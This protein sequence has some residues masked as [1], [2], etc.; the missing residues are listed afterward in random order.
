MWR[1]LHTALIIFALALPC[2]GQDSGV[3]SNYFAVQQQ[4]EWC[5]SG[6]VERCQAAGIAVTEPTLWDYWTGQNRAKLLNVKVDIKQCIPYF[7]KPTISNVLETLQTEGSSALGWSNHVHF[8]QDVG[9]PTNSLDETPYFKTQYHDVTGGWQNVHVMIT[10]LVRTQR[11]MTYWPRTNI[12]SDA[13]FDTVVDP[14]G[15]YWQGWS[16]LINRTNTTDIAKLES[17]YVANC[18][19]ALTYPPQTLYDDVPGYSIGQIGLDPN[20][21]GWFQSV[22]VYTY[23]TDLDTVRLGVSNH[24]AGFSFDELPR[25]FV[26]AYGESSGVF[27]YDPKG[28]GSVRAT[29]EK[30]TRNMRDALVWPG[31]AG[32]E[33]TYG[34]DVFPQSGSMNTFSQPHMITG[35][36]RWKCERFATNYIPDE[37]DTNYT[38][39]VDHTNRVVHMDAPGG[40]Y[41]VDFYVTNAVSTNGYATNITEQIIGSDF[42]VSFANNSILGSRKENENTGIYLPSEFAGHNWLDVT[43]NHYGFVTNIV[44]NIS[45]EI[46]WVSNSYVGYNVTYDYVVQDAVSVT[47]TP[48]P[49][50][51]Y[52]I[53]K[54]DPPCRA[55]KTMV[56]NY[57][58]LRNLPTNIAHTVDSFASVTTYP[59]NNDLSCWN[60]SSVYKYTDTKNSSFDAFGLGYTNGWHVNSSGVTNSE[61]YYFGKLWG[62][63]DLTYINSET[64]CPWPDSLGAS[65]DTEVRG[66]IVSENVAT[67]WWDFQYK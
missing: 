19:G 51:F 45:N 41:P 46:T 23:A 60:F 38:V 14:G 59:T 56:W 3:F 35:Q 16:A 47:N 65:S 15:P 39:T 30:I 61:K 34:D 17:N 27:I 28:A 13:D 20:N 8:L 9:L 25:Q 11:A 40:A 50:N 48:T 42:C 4:A 55:L 66:W 62:T 44:L 33:F 29:R 67:L 1:C 64:N 2:F 36:S 37:G 58:V 31:I 49:T 10:N 53:P 21:G 63:N 22:E 54:Y 24:I 57:E 18:V 6:R 43:N 32:W 26:S 52:L 7:I 12:T 5:H